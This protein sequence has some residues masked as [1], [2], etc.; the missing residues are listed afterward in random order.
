MI[1][2]ID[3]PERKIHGQKSPCAGHDNPDQPE[4][5]IP[6]ADEPR[7]WMFVPRCQRHPNRDDG[8][9]PR[10]INFN[11]MNHLSIPRPRL[12]HYRF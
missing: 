2:P 1:A 11:Y 7:L 5:L 3:Y 10:Q 9:Q 6:Q 12:S 8:K 4:E